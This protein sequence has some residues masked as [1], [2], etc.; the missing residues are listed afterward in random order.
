MV[1]TPGRVSVCNRVQKGIKN[2]P[3]DA[4]SRMRSTKHA[5]V[6]SDDGRPSY[7]TDSGVEYYMSAYDATQRPSVANYVND[8]PLD[9]W[10]EDEA[11][12]LDETLAV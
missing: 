5:I 6:S 8:Q 11:D 12:P 4:M 9:N 2:I 1:V 3:G 7:P 10:S